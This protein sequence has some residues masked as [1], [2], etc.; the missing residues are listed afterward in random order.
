MLCI[1]EAGL[2]E[3]LKLHKEGL[4]MMIGEKGIK[5]SGGERQR[6]GIEEHYM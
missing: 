1:K 6:L 2:T 5:L 3:F 4:H